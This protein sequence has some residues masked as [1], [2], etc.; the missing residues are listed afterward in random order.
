MRG[1]ILVIQIA[2][3]LL[4]LLLAPIAGASVGGGSVA[5]GSTRPSQNREMRTLH[6]RSCVPSEPA[7]AMV[8]SLHRVGFKTACRVTKKIVSYAWPESD[9]T[10]VGKWC[11]NWLGKVHEFEGWAVKVPNH[12]PAIL[13]R[14]G[15]WFAFLGQE[16][17]IG[18]T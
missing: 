16:F 3:A 7:R 2:V 15:R 14:P 11:F 4:A 18:C 1:G 8:A 9:A 6:Y 5:A 10:P 13:S 17:P 12:G